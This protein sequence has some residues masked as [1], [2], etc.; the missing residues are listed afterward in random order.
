MDPPNYRP[1][2]L[3]ELGAGSRCLSHLALLVGLGGA[4]CAVIGYYLWRR[5]KTG[6]PDDI[7]S[8]N[9]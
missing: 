2:E 7:G 1:A 8:M 6:R 4:V 9:S 5:G 3:N